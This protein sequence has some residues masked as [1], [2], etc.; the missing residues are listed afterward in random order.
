[1]M[2]SCI[3]VTNALDGPPYQAFV[4]TNP[5]FDEDDWTYSGRVIVKCKHK[6]REL[7]AAVMCARQLFA[8]R[9]PRQFVSGVIDSG[10]ALPAGVVRD[11]KDGV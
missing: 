2:V 3:P 7:Q 1:M 8:K 6:H 9:C 5:I 4:I 11:G 10:P